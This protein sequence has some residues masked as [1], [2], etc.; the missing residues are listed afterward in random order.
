MLI[1]TKN[2]LFNINNISVIKYYTGK[3]FGDEDSTWLEI[4]LLDRK[5]AFLFSGTSADAFYNALIVQEGITFVDA[6]LFGF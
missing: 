6:E 5:G 3:V 4:E 1:G 2:I